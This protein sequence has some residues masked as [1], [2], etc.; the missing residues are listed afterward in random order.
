MVG[1]FMTELLGNWGLDVFLQRDPLQAL[2]W[3]EEHP[4]TVDLVITDQTMPRMT[5]LELASR[6]AAARGN[7]P[8]LL[9]TGDAARF[10]AAELRRCGVH[11]LLRKP[12]D[13]K[14]LRATIDAL[15]Q[16]GMAAP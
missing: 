7:L 3:L 4:Q 14:G 9:Y 13:P 8:V 1:D 12:I 11:R 15:L 2:E 10:D 6:I 16:D 5:G